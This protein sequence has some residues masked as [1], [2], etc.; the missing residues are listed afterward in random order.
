[1]PEFLNEHACSARLVSTKYF[2]ATSK[3]GHR[4]DKK[5]AARRNMNQVRM[6]VTKLGKERPSPPPTPLTTTSVLSSS[7]GVKKGSRTLGLALLTGKGGREGRPRRL[8]RRRNV[9][10]RD[11]TNLTFCTSPSRPRLSHVRIHPEA[12]SN[13]VV[14]LRENVL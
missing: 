6:Y 4:S 11:W 7:H 1:M 10:A 3:F 8:T 2:E 9:F 12:L 14:R 13:I 5:G